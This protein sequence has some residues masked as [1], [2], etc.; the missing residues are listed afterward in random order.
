ML[1]A[2]VAVGVSDAGDPGWLVADY[3]SLSWVGGAD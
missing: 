2:G 3:C 1:A